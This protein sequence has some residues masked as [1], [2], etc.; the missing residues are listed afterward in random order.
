MSAST[1]LCPIGLKNNSEG[2]SLTFSKQLFFLLEQ[3]VMISG[4]NVKNSR[5]MFFFFLT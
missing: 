4:Q 3:E 5:V 1:F 2:L